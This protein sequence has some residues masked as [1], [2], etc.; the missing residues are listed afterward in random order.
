MIDGERVM[1]DFLESDE[2]RATPSNNNYTLR[3]QRG[4]KKIITSKL[5]RMTCSETEKLE[6][7][8]A[9]GNSSC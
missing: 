5:R 6:F 2:G 9:F 7:P 4:E 1:S 3:Q 8:T